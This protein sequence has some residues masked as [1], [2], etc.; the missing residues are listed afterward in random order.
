MAEY[1]FRENNMGMSED[2]KRMRK[3]ILEIA[4]SHGVRKTSIFG[5]VARG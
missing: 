2:V 4:A 1:N 5:S 3:N